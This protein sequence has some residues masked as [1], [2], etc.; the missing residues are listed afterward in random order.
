MNFYFIQYYITV[1]RCGN[2][3]FYNSLF[4]IKKSHFKSPSSSRPWVFCSDIFFYLLCFSSWFF[5]RF[6]FEAYVANTDH[7]LMQR[8]SFTHRFWEGFSSW[9]EYENV[10]LQSHILHDTTLWHLLV[11]LTGA[12]KILSDSTQ[13]LRKFHAYLL[14][15]VYSLSIQ[16]YYIYTHLT[17]LE[18]CSILL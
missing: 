12:F 11:T 17:S 4:R 6:Y 3:V 18:F 1:E 16:L 13:V 8:V 2:T 15:T 14:F 10:Q 5:L 7:I 9:T